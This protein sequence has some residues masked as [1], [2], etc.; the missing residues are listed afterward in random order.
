MSAMKGMAHAIISM[1]QMGNSINEIQKM[2]DAYEFNQ[3]KADILRIVNN[4]SQQQ[5]A[6]N[7]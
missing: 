3:S 4:I 5:V 2:L 1:Y 6:Q 7:T